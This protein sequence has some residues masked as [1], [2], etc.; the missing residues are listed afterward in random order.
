MARFRDIIH[1]PSQRAAVHRGPNRLVRIAEI[2][3]IASTLLGA[4][5]L[6]AYTIHKNQEQTNSGNQLAAMFD[7]SGPG[8]IPREDESHRVID[9]TTTLHVPGSPI[10]YSMESGLDNIAGY[11]AAES[12]Y[13]SKTGSKMPKI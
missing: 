12:R 7:F 10:K 6:A 8:T 11:I 4:L 13:L 2:G 1:A 5:A 9:A 3:G